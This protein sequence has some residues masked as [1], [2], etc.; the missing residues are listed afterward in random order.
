MLKRLLRIYVRENN[1]LGLIHIGSV[2]FGRI[3]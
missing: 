3:G 1:G 2:S